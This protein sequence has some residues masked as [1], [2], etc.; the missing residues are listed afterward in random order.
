MR[1]IINLI[2]SLFLNERGT[3]QITTAF[4]EGFKQN[5][6][7]LSQQKV[8]RLFNKSRKESQNSETDFYERIG[9][10]DANDVLDRHG[11]T[12]INNSPHSRR[13]VDLQDA[14]WG[15]LIDKLDRVRLLIRPDD[16]YVQIAVMALNR[17]KDDV[18]I[19]AALGNARAGK[20]GSTLVALP[21]SRKLV[22]VND[23]KATGASGMNLYTLT[24]MLEKFEEEEV[25]PEMP[26]YFAWSAAVKRQLLNETKATSSD[27]ATV[28][29]LVNGQIDAFMGF[30]FI[31]SER[32]P[33]TSA[34]TTYTKSDG[35]VGAG[36]GS[37]SA[38]ARRCIAWVED[39]MISATGLDLFADIGPRRD[40]R[41][42]TQVFV[43]HSVGAVRLE[44]AK[45]LEVL[46][47]ESL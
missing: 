5:I 37:L 19:A 25:D 14:D 1:A 17:K 13:A 30:Q 26:K 32:L 9:S 20:T 12:P 41:M 8:P 2:F 10:T 3:F 22:A 47:D 38:G 21:N 46:V 23:D 36:A 40:K 44:E 45:V 29:A 31:H 39:G 24:L 11:D 4:V 28:K 43:L 16:A 34:V 7:I 18:F 35:T 33:V 15:D 6:Y 42:S 27:Y